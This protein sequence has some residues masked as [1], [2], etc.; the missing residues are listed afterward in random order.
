M[1]DR[2]SRTFGYIGALLV[3]SITS[4]ARPAA[5]DARAIVL[6]LEAPSDLAEAAA[7]LDEA[8]RGA[9]EPLSAP[10]VTAV[11]RP[12][13]SVAA[14]LRCT[15]FDGACLGALAL[16]NGADRV[17]F[18]RLEPRAGAREDASVELSLF[19]AFGGR[20][21]ERTSVAVELD[22]AAAADDVVTE[23]LRLLALPSFGAIAVRALPGAVVRLDGALV[24]LVP[25][26][27][28]LEVWPVPEGRHEMRI[29][30]P[31]GRT[32]E[33]PVHV[34]PELVATVGIGVADLSDASAIA[35][36]PRARRSGDDVDREPLPTVASLEA[37]D[38]GVVV[39]R[40][41]EVLVSMAA[42]T[43]ESV[44]PAFTTTALRQGIPI[45]ENLLL[46]GTLLGMGARVSA[47][48]RF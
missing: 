8:L 39:R 25:S 47:K 5:A 41:C 9:L 26:D 11:H 1:T 43:V 33:F 6:G 17:L 18:G 28:Q 22:E 7:H 20:V 19:D 21:V 37:S 36:A 24:G 14:A 29:E 4:V 23:A 44:G 38:D 3:V 15:G 46:H 16:R 35:A 12:P 2:L 30:R 45:E 27:G 34:E 48:L 40:P 10:R 32:C 13:S 31:D 42:R